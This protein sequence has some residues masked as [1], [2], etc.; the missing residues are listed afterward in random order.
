MRYNDAPI[1]VYFTH[2][3][4]R[5]CRMDTKT[6]KKMREEFYE[7][8]DQVM[9]ISKFG[10]QLTKEQLYLKTSWVCSYPRVTI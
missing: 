4:K 7:S 1:T 9:H 6:R 2:L 8:R 3:D 10:K 5:W